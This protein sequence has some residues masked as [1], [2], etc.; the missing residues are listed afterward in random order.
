ML[1]F[2]NRKQLTEL[3]RRLID[4]VGD[5]AKG[6]TIQTY[7]GLSLRLTG[8]AMTT[9]EPSAESQNQHFAEVIKEAADLLRGD[10]PLLGVD[11]DETRERLLAGY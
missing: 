11:V 1:W 10:K 4:L 7:H 9:R 8:H 6:I 2:D 5:D 3:R